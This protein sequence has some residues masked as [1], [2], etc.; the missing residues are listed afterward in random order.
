VRCN[1]SS[2]AAY[3]RSTA[4]KG[5]ILDEILE[6]VSAPV[7]RARVGIL[8]AELES[9]RGQVT[10]LR[11]LAGQTAVLHLNVPEAGRCY[12]V[13]HRAFQTGAHLERAIA[14]ATLGHW[15]W[16]AEANGR[17]KTDAGQVVYPAG[18]LTA[19]QKVLGH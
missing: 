8:V 7:L 5:S 19:I 2:N 11:H 3:A 10:A 16:L 14:P 4:R 18:Y 1:D 6:G 9:A 13:R 12:A 17:V 15:E